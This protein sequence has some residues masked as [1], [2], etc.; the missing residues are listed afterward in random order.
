MGLPYEEYAAQLKRIE[1][2]QEYLPEYNNPDL[3]MIN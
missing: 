1:R 2:E 3:D